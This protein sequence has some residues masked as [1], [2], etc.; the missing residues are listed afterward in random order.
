MK[1]A[2]QKIMDKREELRI[3]LL[4]EIK[5][6]VTQATGSSI[7]SVLAQLGSLTQGLSLRDGADQGEV[8]RVTAICKYLMMNMV[9]CR[10]KCSFADIIDAEIS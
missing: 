7:A 10:E 1:E 9:Y 4:P 2:V 3:R 6:T 8:A 5:V